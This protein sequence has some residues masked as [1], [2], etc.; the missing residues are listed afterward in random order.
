M[1]H[2]GNVRFR[3]LVQSRYEQ[4]NL[5]TTKALI[6][7]MFEDIERQSL[8]VLMWNEKSQYFSVVI[9]PQLVYKKIE[10]LVRDF[11]FSSTKSQTINR[12]IADAIAIN[13]SDEEDVSTNHTNLVRKIESLHS[14]SSI[15]SAQDGS[16]R[17]KFKSNIFCMRSGD[18]SDS[19][20]DDERTKCY[21]NCNEL[22]T[23]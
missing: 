4:G 20:T 1:L 3:S 12:K 22:F 18:V 7:A 2:P 13:A 19:S 6:T 14:D 10:Y 17:K 8:R 15:F 9:D 16:S 5:L 23:F 11:Q 21:S